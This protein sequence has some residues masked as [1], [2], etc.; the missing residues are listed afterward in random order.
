MNYFVLIIIL[1]LVTALASI[2]NAYISLSAL[3][4]HRK[5]RIIPFNAYRQSE[6]ESPKETPGSQCKILR[7]PTEAE[8]ILAELFKDGGRL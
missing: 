2:F 7:E 3:F 4:K 5:P 6:P 8:K 1:N